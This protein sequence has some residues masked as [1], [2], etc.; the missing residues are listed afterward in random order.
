M[1]ADRDPTPVRLEGLPRPRH[2][3]RPAGARPTNRQG[4]HR[5]AQARPRLRRRRAQ[6]ARDRRVKLPRQPAKQ[7]RIPSRAHIQAI[8][9]HL[10]IAFDTL[11]ATGIRVGEL[12]NLTWADLDTAESR[13]RIAQGKTPPPDA[14]PAPPNVTHQ[15]NATRPPGTSPRNAAC[16]PCCTNEQ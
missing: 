3:P 12:N 8:R 11:E 6:P 7:P 5:H 4:L 2:Q 14:G 10:L 15:I 13:A 1:I 9:N 16:F